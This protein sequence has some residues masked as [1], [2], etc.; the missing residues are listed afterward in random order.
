MAINFGQCISTELQKIAAL[1]LNDMGLAMTP[2]TQFFVEPAKR[3]ND[4][5]NLTQQLEQQ[6]RNQM[7]EL[8]LVKEFLNQK[9]DVD[10]DSLMME[11]QKPE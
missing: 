2:T 7:N 6:T 10:L 5:S 8:K 9:F 11:H 1:Q 3:L 4:L